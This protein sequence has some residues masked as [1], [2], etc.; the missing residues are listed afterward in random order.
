MGAVSIEARLTVTGSVL[1]LDFMTAVPIILS[2]KY[3]SQGVAMAAGQAVAKKLGADGYDCGW[4]K[5]TNGSLVWLR[6]LP[7][8]ETVTVKRKRPGEYQVTVKKRRVRKASSHYLD[9]ALKVK[10]K[11]R[12]R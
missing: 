10:R 1:K 12:K 9:R 7:S 8:S 5:Q 4:L 2:C 6:G 3:A 11:T